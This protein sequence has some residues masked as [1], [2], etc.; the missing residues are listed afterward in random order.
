MNKNGDLGLND[1]RTYIPDKKTYHE[2][3]TWL[4]EQG[5]ITTLVAVRL[6]CELGMTRIEIVNAKVNDV[7]TQNK[8]CLTIRIA[9]RVRR[10]SKTVNGKKVPNFQMRIRD[11][12]I[13]VNL[14]QLLKTYMKNSEIY[15]LHREKGDPRKH[16]I[17]R[18]INYL[19]ESSDICWSPHKSRHY[20]KSQ[21]WSWMMKNRQPDRAL[22]QDFMGH[23]RDTVHDAY[24]EYAW[25]YK[26][27]VVDGVFG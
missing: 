20:F 2:T 24:G 12:P 9:K 3:L 14:Y 27:E 1:K 10:G 15:I 19:Y 25:D 6:G 8:R 17:P 11:V 26:L 4:T 22:L 7:D 23:Q 16:F 5:E 21:V 18:Y 13:N